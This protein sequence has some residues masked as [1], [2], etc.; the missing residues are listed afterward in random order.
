MMGRRVLALLALLV[1][2]TGCGYSW[3]GT[4]PPHVRTV[5]VP[6]FANRTQW[7]NIEAALTAAVANAFATDGRLK[8]VQPAEADAILE[9]EIVNYQ[10]SVL[11]F[12]SNA[13]AQQYRLFVTVDVRFRDVRRGAMSTSAGPG[14]GGLPGGTAGSGHHRPTDAAIVPTRP[15]WPRHRGARRRPSRRDGARA[16]ALTWKRSCG[17]RRT[18]P[19]WPCSAVV[20]VNFDDALAAVSMAFPEPSAAVFDREVLDGG[21]RPWRQSSIGHDAPVAAPTLAVAVRHCSCPPREAR[22]WPS[23]P[24]TPIPAPVCYCLPTT[25]SRPRAIG[26]ITGCSAPC[27]PGR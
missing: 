12:D 13:N 1:L 8:V 2:G 11:A 6:V 15:S 16:D 20:T 27:P 25:H 5:G 19:P 18:T 21:R 22:S 24:R 4:L 26:K 10:V 9:G 23:T 7:P 14:A 17:R 3:R